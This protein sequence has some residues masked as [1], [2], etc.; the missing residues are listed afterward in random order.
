MHGL[1]N[2]LFHFVF[3]ALINETEMMLK[4]FY[5]E[6]LEIL[7]QAEARF[8][9]KFH[10]IWQGHGIRRIGCSVSGP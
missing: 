2:K 8:M 6:G 1:C 5:V 10:G 4:I 3:A 7:R 9:P